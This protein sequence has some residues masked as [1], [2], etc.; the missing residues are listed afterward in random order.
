MQLNKF[1]ALAGIC[2][3]R[4]AV[5]LIKEGHVVV[6]GSAI[7]EPG[8]RVPEKARVTVAGKPVC[9]EP[10]KYILLNKPSDCV[11]TA[12]DEHGRRTVLDLLGNAFK[13]RLYPIGRLDRETTGLLLL[14]N[15]GDF[16]Q[17]IAHPRFT[18][19]KK[20]QVMLDRPLQPQD[21]DKVCNGVR[22]DDGFV[23][24]D[25]IEPIGSGRHSHR[26]N[27]LLHSGRYRIIR[28]IFDE[29]GYEVIRLD[30]TAIGHLTKKGLPLGSW[31]LL[32]PVELAAFKMMR[33]QRKSPKSRIYKQS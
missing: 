26:F 20:Y 18:I 30:R 31:R 25:Y 19:K 9:H 32:S 12:S 7:K 33:T 11:S 6:N 27:I 21:L 8:F 29:L 10:K 4:K 2:S 23:R 24:I 5:D 3:R 28:R 22:L 13:E 1:I 14:T 15:D 17:S 16:A